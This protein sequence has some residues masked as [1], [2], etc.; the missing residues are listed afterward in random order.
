MSLACPPVFDESGFGLLEPAPPAQE[1]RGRGTERAN[2]QI[3]ASGSS[4]RRLLHL[5]QLRQV[6]LNRRQRLIATNRQKPGNRN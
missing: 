1:A 5:G 4:R 2:V 3:I 6:Q